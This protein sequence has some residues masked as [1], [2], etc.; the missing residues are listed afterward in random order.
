MMNNNFDPYDILM[1]VTDRLHR[2]EI[3]HNKN[4]DTFRK[5]EVDLQVALHSLRNLQQKH[6]QL[7][8]KVHQLEYQLTQKTSQ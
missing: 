6:I 8:Q 7:T 1:Q 3:A 5:T 2:L 4:A